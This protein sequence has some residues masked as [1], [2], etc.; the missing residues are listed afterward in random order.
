M[1]TSSSRRATFASIA[2]VL[3]A[4]LAY[5]LWPQTAPPPVAK[6]EAPRKLPPLKLQPSLSS[7]G[8]HSPMRARN[9]PQLQAQPQD[10]EN[11]SQENSEEGQAPE[12]SRPV[13]G[14]EDLRELDE[15]LVQ[16]F[17][18]GLV[19]ENRHLLMPCFEKLA[20]RRDETADRSLAIDFDL[21]LDMKVE[22][23]VGIIAG[24]EFVEPPEIVG[25][26]IQDCFHEKLLEITFDGADIDFEGRIE[27][28]VRL[29]PSQIE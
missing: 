29:A 26:A 18:A 22:E 7:E 3:A 15:L 12:G 25:E 28:P 13:L 14:V 24:V 20:K 4:A 16:R 2:A 17:Q 1:P 5:L 23:D 6:P 8:T 27:Y 21:I 19:D 9:R 11:N 10:I